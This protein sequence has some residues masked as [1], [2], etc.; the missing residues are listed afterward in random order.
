MVVLCWTVPSSGVVVV[1]VEL[2]VAGAG[3]TTG[4]LL[5]SILSFLLTKHPLISETALAIVTTY[6]M[7]L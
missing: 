3:V 2:C 1:V 7:R 4:D 6:A 5:S